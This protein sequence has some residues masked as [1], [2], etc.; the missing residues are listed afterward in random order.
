M[1][2]NIIIFANIFISLL[3]GYIKFI[4]SGDKRVISKSFELIPD[5]APEISG[6]IRAPSIPALS[7]CFLSLIIAVILYNNNVAAKSFL[8]T[9]IVIAVMACFTILIF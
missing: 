6:A 4:S 8:V 1:K 3:S 9:N 7:I 5:L 2:N